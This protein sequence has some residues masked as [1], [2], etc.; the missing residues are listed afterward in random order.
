M[1]E[2]KYQRELRGRLEAAL[3]DCMIIRN[4]PKQLQGIPDLLVLYRSFWAA[5]EVKDDASSPYQPNQEWY[6]AHMND[7]SFAS[8]IHPQNEE[9]V[10][11]A[12]QATFGI[13]R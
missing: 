5:L 3:P 9:E 13:A 10:I 2:T 4:D 7:M 1:A 8:V 11:H 12:L 6:L